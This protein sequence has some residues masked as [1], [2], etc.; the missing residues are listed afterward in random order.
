MTAKLIKLSSVCGRSFVYLQE[1]T[2]DVVALLE[3]LANNQ[4]SRSSFLS[5]MVRYETMQHGNLT[6]PGGTVMH[7][8]G[9]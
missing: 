6:L 5:H 9:S 3:N 8:N 4:T 2:M 1:M 7:F